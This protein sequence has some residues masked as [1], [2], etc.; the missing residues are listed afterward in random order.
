MLAAIER[1]R[2][3]D[4]EVLMLREWDQLSNAEIGELIGAGTHAVEMRM[5]RAVRRLAHALDHEERAWS[6]THA[7]AA[8]GGGES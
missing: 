4:R 3:Q 7:S 2:P 1:L 8:E 5:H 6:R